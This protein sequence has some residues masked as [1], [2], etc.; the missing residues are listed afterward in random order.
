MTRRPPPAAARSAALR[1]AAPLAVAVLFAPTLGCTGGSDAAESERA[2]PSAV[3]SQTV[4]SKT[5]EVDRLYRSMKGPYSVQQVRLLDGDVP[6]LLWIVGYEAVM[7]ADDGETEMP[8]E[9]MCH[10]NLDI[11]VQAHRKAIPTNYTFSPRLFTL[12]QGQ[13][14][15]D[16]PRGFGIPVLS[17]QSLGLTTQVLNLNHPHGSRQVR[18]KVS[19]RYVRDAEAGPMRALFPT[20]AYG[21][22]LL[23][24]EGGYFGVEEPDAEEQGPGCLAAA[25]AADHTYGDPQGRKFTGHWVVKPGREENRTLVTHLMNLPYDTTIHYIAVHL[26]PFAESLELRDLTS[27]ETLFKSNARNFG[28]KIGLAAV[29]AF[30]SAEGIAVFRDHEYELVSVY[31]NSTSE[32]QDS[33]AVMYLYLEDRD[34]DRSRVKATAPT[35]AAA[36]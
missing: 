32:D 18:H 9:F 1:L 19:I 21:L 16:F 33:M 10:S 15:I 13:L 28:D 7:V 14:E 25:N 31:Q 29:D 4:L 23:E 5:Y 34:F 22:A 27:G 8:Q 35:T 11:D 6:E 20:G 12:S 26:H 24:G 17:T 36:G 30:S 3:A 2:M